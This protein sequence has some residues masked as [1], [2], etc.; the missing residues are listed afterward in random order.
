[1]D[2]E[3]FLKGLLNIINPMVIFMLYSA[4][5]NHEKYNKRTIVVSYACYYI[6]TTYAYLYVNTPIF[7]I[8]TNILASFLLTFL[9]ESNIL[10]K[11]YA[12]LIT[13]GFFFIIETIFL[14]LWTNSSV[15]LVKSI[16]SDSMGNVIMTKSTIFLIANLIYKRFNKNH[17]DFVPKRYYIFLS[18]MSFMTIVIVFLNVI[19]LDGYDFYLAISTILLLFMNFI[20]F[21]IYNDMILLFE[22]QQSNVQLENHYN[23]IKSQSNAINSSTEELRRLEHDLKNKL[24]PISY[25]A[26]EGKFTELKE[27]L[28]NIIGDLSSASIYKDT[29]I[30]ELDGI[31]NMKL[32][33]SKKQNINLDI[34]LS[35]NK[36]ANINGMDLALIVGTLLDNAMEATSKVSDKWINL[37]INNAYEVVYVSVENSYNG[38]VLLKNG[39]LLTT[40]ADKKGHGIGLM[41]IRKVIKKYDG[42]MDIKYTNSTFKNSVMLYSIENTLEY[43]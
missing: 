27:H 18:L 12:F 3:I 28:D 23:L 6:L 11:I 4:I 36:D 14:I 32:R 19:I 16:T 37:I 40:K 41:S 9:Y 30:P 15:D 39:E 24:T 22:K 38:V 35:I 13:Y 2:I 33:E 5:F 7:N 34:K 17:S 25:M 21:S 8:I 31:L 10:K 43:H 26:K 20:F 29:Q 42:E 1:M